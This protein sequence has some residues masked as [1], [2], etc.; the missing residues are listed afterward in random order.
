MTRD[1]LTTSRRRIGGSSFTGCLAVVVLA[2]FAGIWGFYHFYYYNELVKPGNITILSGTGNRDAE[3][4]YYRKM[5]EYHLNYMAKL[6]TDMLKFYGDTVNKH[7]YANHKDDFEQRYTEILNTLNEHIHEFDQQLV[8]K[9]ISAAHL[10]IS[11]SHNAFY[12]CLLNLHRGYYEAKPE[13]TA[14][15]KEARLR[16]DGGIKQDLQGEAEARKV[17]GT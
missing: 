5:R 7:L 15:Y 11:L 3:L 6:R 1:R 14:A 10:K 8:P 9:K 17:L 16:L 13:Q 12:E 4:S 2:L